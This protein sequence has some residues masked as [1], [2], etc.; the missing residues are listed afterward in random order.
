MT[1]AIAFECAIH[2]L[3]GNEVTVRVAD[4]NAYVEIQVAC[5]S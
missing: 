4:A 1:E 5:F 2:A 3:V